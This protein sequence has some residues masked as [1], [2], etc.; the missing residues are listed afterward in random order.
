MISGL[1]IYNHKGDLVISRTYRDDITKAVVD[2]FRANVI[3]SRTGTRPPV[4]NMGKKSFCHLYRNQ[5]WFVAVTT[6][7]A[8]AT[9]IF[10]FM[11]KF[12]ALCGAYFG[13]F[14]EINVKNHFSL[15]YELLDEVLDN[16]Y[17]QSTDPEVLKII[18]EDA[19]KKGATLEDVKN[20]SSQ[21]TGQIGWRRA[22]IKYRKNEIYLDVIEKVN[23]LI[24]PSGQELS[25]HVAG[26]IKMKAYLSGM[27]DCKFGI[28]DK[29]VSIKRKEDKEGSKSKKKK[30][31]STPIAIDD[32]TFH[33]CVKLGRFDTNRSISFVPPD[34][35]FELMKYRTTSDVILPFVVTPII[36]ENDQHVNMSII[37][38]SDFEEKHVATKVVVTIPT[39]TNAS[40]VS[41]PSSGTS[42]GKAKYKGGANAV[43][44]KMRTF[45][46][47]K[48]AQCDIRID[49]LQSAKKKKWI[50]PPIRLDFEVPFAC[51]GL[52]V[53]YLL[54]RENKLGYD[55]SDVMKWVRYIGSSGDYE[56]RY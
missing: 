38:K 37:L 39:P 41:V 54:V 5:L 15:I 53:E 45:G 47:K 6:D 26:I 46:G 7:N 1:F 40:N 56:A 25:S 55:D 12:I 44:W 34:G 48:S 8:N 22:D 36:Q 19:S 49:L 14:N 50:R 29:L 28:N 11:N 21:V 4:N 42:K 17:P 10:E 16:G 32:L 30:Q 3:H 31:T 27:P 23:C 35:E 24:S 13:K 51:S 43:V 33:Q 52:Q 9:M 20:I 18:T 2:A